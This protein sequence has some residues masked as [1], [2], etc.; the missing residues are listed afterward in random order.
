[1]MSCSVWGFLKQ[2]LIRKSRDLGRSR[3][4]PSLNSF[5]QGLTLHPKR[6]ALLPSFCLPRFEGFRSR[7]VGGVAV[8]DYE[9]A[10]EV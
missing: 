4:G 7:T 10:L 6:C 5:I 2:G 3:V 8:K 1:M 9:G